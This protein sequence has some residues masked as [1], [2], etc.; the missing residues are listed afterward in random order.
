[1]SDTHA[2]FVRALLML[3]MIAISINVNNF[4]RNIKFHYISETA[5]HIL[6]GFIVAM[7]W[8]AIEYDTTNS[9]IQLSSNFFY[10]VL[11]PPIIFEGGFTLQKISFFKNL[12]TIVSL[13][14]AGALYSTFVTSVIMYYL[15]KLVSPWTLIESLVF[16]S[17][18]SSTDPVTVLSLL[19]SNVDKR[20][21]MII[22]GESAL[23][24]AVSIILYRFFTSLEDPTMRLG[25]GPFFVSVF[26]SAGVFLGSVCVGI[27][28]ALIFALLTKHLVV[29]HERPLFETVMLI[30][31]AY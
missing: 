18:I 6:V 16:G 26:A 25:A 15:S 11:L 3:T 28:M 9:D 14:F 29:D 23:N 7:L 13:A 8:T 4:F 30:V 19:P 31:F 12:L 22:F 20:L 5:V 24:D 1:M 10:M 17:L 2:L 21:Y 27:A